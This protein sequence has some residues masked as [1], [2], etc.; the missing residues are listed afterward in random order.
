MILVTGATGH[1]GNVLVKKLTSRGRAVRV[2]ILPGDDLRSLAG[3][4]VE[5]V[6]GDITDF[7]SILPLFEDVDVVFHLAGIISIMSGQDELLYRVNVM[8]TQNV[9]EAC[10]KNSVDRLVYTSSVHALREPPHGTQIDETCFYEP[11][12]SR[13]GYDRTKAQ[14]SLEVLE[15]VKKGLDAVIVC[16]SGVIGPCDYNIS[17]MGQLILNYMNGNMKA[18]IDGAYD[19]VDV[20]DVAEGLILACRRGETGESYILSGEKITVLELMRTLE[21]IT[22]VK[23]PWLKVPHW[24][25]NVAGKL[26][27]LYYRNRKSKPLFTSYSAEVLLSNC[28]INNFKA[29][30]DLGYDPR[31]LK[32]S[33]RDSVEWFNNNSPVF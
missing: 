12:Y 27:P 21:E 14:A 15:G 16:P 25:A 17:Q 28:N 9:V 19:F 20:R 7:D 2:L 8:G 6:E 23:G 24:M 18:Y 13:G 33:L 32:E 3:L 11:E 30:K 29:R 1:I 5:I 31:P 26:T 10:L 22:G 4:D